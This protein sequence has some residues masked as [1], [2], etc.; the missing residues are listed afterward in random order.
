METMMQTLM[1]AI[2]V[3]ATFRNCVL[4]CH[5]ELSISVV[6]KVHMVPVLAYCILNV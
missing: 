1:E 4:L 6:Y 5:L 3:V 2:L